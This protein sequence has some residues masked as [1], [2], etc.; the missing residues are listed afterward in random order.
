LGKEFFHKKKYDPGKFLALL[1]EELKPKFAELFL[2]Q[3]Q[4]EPEKEID[5]VTLELKKLAI[6]ESLNELSIKITKAEKEDGQKSIEALEK[7][8]ARKA[9]KLVELSHNE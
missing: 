2:T 5:L 1:P 8:F 6:K 3:D 7:E 4:E 9:S